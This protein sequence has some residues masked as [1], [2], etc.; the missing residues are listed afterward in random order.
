MAWQKMQ[1]RGPKARYEYAEQFRVITG[2]YK[3]SLILFQSCVK[4]RPISS[5]VF[6]LY[7]AH[8]I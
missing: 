7:C 6:V 4:M 2:I 3:R 5:L 8:K 1:V